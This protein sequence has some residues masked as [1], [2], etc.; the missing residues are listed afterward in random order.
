MAGYIKTKRH[1]DNYCASQQLNNLYMKNKNISK[2]KY[3]FGQEDKKEKSG[4]TL[5]TI[6]NFILTE[7]VKEEQN[8]D[9]N[10]IRR[11][12]DI[13]YSFTTTNTGI[14]NAL[15]FLDE[16]RNVINNLDYYNFNPWKA[17]WIFTKE[18]KNERKD[19]IH[20]IRNAMDYKGEVSDDEDSIIKYDETQ[21]Q[22][23]DEI[24]KYNRNSIKAEDKPNIINDDKPMIDNDEL[25]TGKV[26]SEEISEEIVIPK[27]QPKSECKA[28]IIKPIALNNRFLDNRLYYHNVYMRNRD[29][30]AKKNIAIGYSSIFGDSES[31]LMNAYNNNNL[32][33]QPNDN[34]LYTSTFYNVKQ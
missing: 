33:Q 30:L 5:S 2:I 1:M 8:V 31:N 6:K 16:R 20:K 11:M 26:D 29:I 3:L 28:N 21:D 4:L 27:N 10:K 22:L 24:I 14:S 12:K 7:S 13:L 19:M 9:Y 18:Y 25:I 15:I 23:N 34:R 17:D 32:F